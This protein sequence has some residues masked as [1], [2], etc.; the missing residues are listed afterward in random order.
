LVSQVFWF[1]RPGFEIARRLR[2][3]AAMPFGTLPERLLSDGRARR[4]PTVVSLG[5]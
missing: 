5:Q 3:F 2:R 1:G 4:N